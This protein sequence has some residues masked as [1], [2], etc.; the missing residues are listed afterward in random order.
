VFELRCSVIIRNTADVY[1]AIN[2]MPPLRSRGE[3]G[4][5]DMELQ[6][7]LQPPAVQS[8]GRFIIWIEFS[9]HGLSLV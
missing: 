8:A 9:T 1:E 5:V 2:T 7:E 4:K 3:L 6:H